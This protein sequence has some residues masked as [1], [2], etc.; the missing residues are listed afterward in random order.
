MNKKR[1]TELDIDPSII[2]E[3]PPPEKTAERGEPAPPPGK[4]AAEKPP[5]EAAEKAAPKKRRINYLKL[6][7]LALAG[8]AMLAVAG[9]L[10]FA[11][12][13]LIHSLPEETTA[14]QPAQAPPPAPVIPRKPAPAKKTV[15]IPA[16]PLYEFEPFFITL[17]DGDDV[18]LIRAGFAARM[19]GENVKEEIERNLTLIRENIYF[20]LGEKKLEDFKDPERRK[21]TSVDVA[22]AINR[23][24][25]SGA[26]EEVFVTS[27]TI[28]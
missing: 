14:E 2:A 23:S 20:V 1:R 7:V 5:E 24:I 6:L 25:Q 27:L 13:A 18:T 9:A 4:P 26:V 11:V 3:K 21:K 10:G 17:V 12:M 8:A 19:S 28:R 22:I 15:K 16:P